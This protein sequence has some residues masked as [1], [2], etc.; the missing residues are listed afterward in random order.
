MSGICDLRAE[1]KRRARDGAFWTYDDV[2]H[3]GGELLDD[4]AGNDGCG[5]GVAEGRRCFSYFKSPF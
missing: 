3:V 5:I 2:C 1:D 4:G